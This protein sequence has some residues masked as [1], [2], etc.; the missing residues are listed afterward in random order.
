MKKT[1]LN[2][3][4]HDAGARMIDFGGWE[5]PVI[6]RDITQEHAAVR[7]RVGLFDLGH[8]GR[9]SVSGPDAEELVQGAQ[10]NDLGRIGD[11]QIRYALLLQDDGGVIDDIL[12]HRRAEDIFLVVNA[13]N[14]DRDVARLRELAGD[15]DV[16]I[17]PLDELD[18]VAV[19]G[20]R[21]AEVMKKLAPELDID[22]L[23]YYRL[24]EGPVLGHDATVTRTGYT[25]E[26]GFEIYAHEDHIAEIWDAALSAGE[27]FGILPCGLGARDTLRLEAGMP[28]YGHEINE[29][30]NPV[31]AGLMFGVRL[32]KSDYPGRDVLA[33]EKKAGPKRRVVGLT[34]EGKRIPREGYAILSGDREVGHVCSGTWSPTFQCAIAT[35]IVDSAVLDAGGELAVDLRGRPTAARRVELPFYKRDGSGSLQQS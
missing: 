27:E 17:K 15:R 1:R 9:I 3:K 6:Y 25:G 11:G 34:L 5:M 16:N 33:A 8:M 23:G 4:H 29:T 12:V 21:S 28:L 26:D 32:K 19:Q 10:S 31:E 24:A 2:Q 22:G 35:A 7:E 30:I 20:P 14:Y 13:S 18:M